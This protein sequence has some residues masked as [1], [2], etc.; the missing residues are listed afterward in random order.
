MAD[1]RGMLRL[2]TGLN[3]DHVIWLLCH[4]RGQ[5]GA[6]SS[7]QTFT[8]PAACRTAGRPRAPAASRIAGWLSF[9]ALA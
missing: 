9:Q 2:R 7:M 8:D 4:A 3:T 5:Q 6:W 1:R